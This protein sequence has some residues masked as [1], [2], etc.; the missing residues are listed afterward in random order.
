MGP[1]LR[2]HCGVE[3]APKP[4]LPRARF[5][6]TIVQAHELKLYV[7]MA[8]AMIVAQQLTQSSLTATS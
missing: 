5:A 3:L 6:P 8:G 4:C 2:V 1:G 7:G